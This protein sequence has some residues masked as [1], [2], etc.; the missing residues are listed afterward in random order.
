MNTYDNSQLTSY[1]K[2]PF[3]YHLQ[4]GLGFKKSTIDDTNAQMQ[5]GTY[6]HKFMEAWFKKEFVSIDKI[7]EGYIEPEGLPQYS[8]HALK[9]FCLTCHTKYKE[10]FKRYEVLETEVCSKLKLSGHNFIVKCDAVVKFNDN[11]FGFENKTTKS[12]SYNYFDRYFLNSQISAQSAVIREKYG[13]CSGVILNV[14]ECKSLKRKPSGNY[15]NFFQI[16]DSWIAQ[17]FSQDIVNR[18]KDEVNDWYIQSVNWIER[19]E[20]DCLSGSF[21]KSCVWSGMVCSSC[22]YKELCKTSVGTK[23]DESIVECLYD[24]V[25]PY[26]YL[27]EV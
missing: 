14:G 22:S 20:D 10:D 12:I 24:T 6:F 9:Q 26:A 23:L 17:K 3:S 2:C 5:F 21:P 8:L 11:I 15:D 1:Q 19:I 27:E 4:Y 16:E 7:L 25:D 13:Q 18:T